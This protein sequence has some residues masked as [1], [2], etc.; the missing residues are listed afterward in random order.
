MKNQELYQR[1]VDIL[2]DAYNAGELEHMSCRACA[3]GNL[4]NATGGFAEPE[5]FVPCWAEVITVYPGGLP[6][7][8]TRY[9]YGNAKKEIDQTGYSYKELSRIEVAFEMAADKD[10]QHNTQY[11]GLCAVLDTLREIH[12]AEAE[13]HENNHKRLTEIFEKLS[14]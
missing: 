5:N 9:Y 1:S 3:V 4:V 10:E 13:P 7:I 11:Y 12:E 14:A 6:L 2:L 8:D